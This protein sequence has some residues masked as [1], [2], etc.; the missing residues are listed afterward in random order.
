MLTQ[1]LGSAE[2]IKSRLYNKVPAN[3][4]FIFCGTVL[5]EGGKENKGTIDFE[6]IKP[7][8]ATIF[9]PGNRFDT[10]ALTEMLENDAKFGF[11]V[12]DG[13][14]ALFRNLVRN[15]SPDFTKK[16]RS[17]YP[18][19]TNE[20]VS[21]PIVIDVRFR[22]SEIISS[23]KWPYHLFSTSSTKIRPTSKVWFPRSSRSSTS[24]MVAKWVS[25][26]PGGLPS[27]RQVHRRK[28]TFTEVI[29]IN[30]FG[31]RKVLPRYRR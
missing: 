18:T 21:L 20:V 2:N 8:R 26:R 4:L 15:Q 7:I 3:G 17:I 14:V 19:S 29:R 23:A 30:Q 1:E 6:P 28:Q 22:R 11:I 27:K 25:I 9:V 13:K 5:T 16:S 10:P 31:N 24:L 12:V